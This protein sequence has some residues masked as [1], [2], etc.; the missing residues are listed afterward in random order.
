MQHSSSSKSWLSQVKV[1]LSARLCNGKSLAVV[2]LIDLKRRNKDATPDMH[3][4]Q[5]AAEAAAVMLSSCEGSKGS[6]SVLWFHQK[7][8]RR[9]T[10]E[11]KANISLSLYNCR[12]VCV[13][14]SV[15]SY[16]SLCSVPVITPLPK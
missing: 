15:A 4:S 5:T 8:Q 16:I 11:G 10:A 7:T 9:M 6:G 2:C 3:T 12:H 13:N 1:V 14:I